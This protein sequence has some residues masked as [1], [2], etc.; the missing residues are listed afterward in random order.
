MLHVVATALCGGAWTWR[1]DEGLLELRTPTGAPIWGFH[2]GADATKPYIY[3]LSL[4]GGP[5]LAALRPPDHPWHLGLWF[6][7][8]YINGVNYWEEDRATGRPA[9]LTTWS[10]VAVRAE[11]DGRAMVTL[12]LAY[13]PIAN[14]PAVLREHRSLWFSAP[15]SDG[16]W[17]L[18]WNAEFTVVTDAIELAATPVN[19]ARTAGGYGGLLCRIS[20]NLADWGAVDERGRRDLAIHGE[21]AC[22]VDFHGRIG[23]CEAGLAILDHPD[24]PGS[25]CPWFLRLDRARGY[26][27]TGP[28][29]L[30]AGPRTYTAG[31]RWRLRYRVIV[32]PGAWSAQRLSREL[33]AFRTVAAP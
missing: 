20:T 2:W 3:P 29:F 7:W 25:P 22:A 8:K 23:D 4:E 31:Q 27:L 10:N 11:R 21:P 1:Q 16:S 17:S 30:F 12:D 19:P 28:G 14:A 18:D 26:G 33:E 5:S 24:N 9:G 15:S 13:R 6:S 32:H